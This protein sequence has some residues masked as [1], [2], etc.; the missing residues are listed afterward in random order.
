MKKAGHST[1]KQ[2]AE[3]AKR[4]NVKKLYLTH[5]SQRYTDARVLEGEARGIFPESYT[6]EDFMKV[7]V[8]KH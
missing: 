8:E 2:A 1:A 4:A 7:K 5:I 6:A 3:V